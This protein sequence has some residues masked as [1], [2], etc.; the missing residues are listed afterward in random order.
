[1]LPSGLPDQPVTKTP[2][3][4][5]IVVLLAVM[6]IG[7]VIWPLM[8]ARGLAPT[9]VEADLIAVAVL[10]FSYMAYKNWWQKQQGGG[11]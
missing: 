4:H 1:M 2:M 6:F 9:G 11:P 3:V 7:M 10:I 8:R 5:P